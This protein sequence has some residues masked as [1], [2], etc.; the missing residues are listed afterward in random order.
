MSRSCRG[1]AL[2]DLLAALAVAALAAAVLALPLQ[3]LREAHATRAGAERLAE[4]FAEARST[5]QRQG[6]V[7]LL[8]VEPAAAHVRL[9]GDTVDQRTLPLPP[10]DALEGAPRLHRYAPDGLLLDA[11]AATYT[12]RAGTAV[13]RVIVAKYGRVRLE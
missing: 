10:L 6:R 7:V 11:G 2:A 9:A 3:R 8:L 4:A 1:L 5:A 12:L 13:R